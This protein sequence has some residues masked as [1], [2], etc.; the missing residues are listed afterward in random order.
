MSAGETARSF[1][2]EGLR[3]IVQRYEEESDEMVSRLFTGSRSRSAPPRPM[4]SKIE[5]VM[6]GSAALVKHG[7]VL[8]HLQIKRFTDLNR[9]RA[10]PGSN[11]RPQEWPKELLD[12]TEDVGGP[13]GLESFASLLRKKACEGI[14]ESQKKGRILSGLQIKSVQSGY[15]AGVDA[16][17]AQSCR[18]SPD[19]N[20]SVFVA[21]SGRRTVRRI[22]SSHSPHRSPRPRLGAVIVQADEGGGEEGEPRRGFEVHFAKCRALFRAHARE[23]IFAT[24]KKWEKECAFLQCFD[25]VPLEDE[26]DRA[27]Q[28]VKLRWSFRGPFAETS[29]TILERLPWFDIQNIATL[30]GRVQIIR[31]DYCLDATHSWK[32]GDSWAN[33]WFHVNR[34]YFDSADPIYYEQDRRFENHAQD[35]QSRH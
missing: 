16:P 14:K 19:G 24:T 35:T 17:S 32:S 29:S 7:V 25:A 20:G 4:K 2:A 11:T 6:G 10:A 33:E 9:A 21:D 1:A 22:V 28:C 3:S 26:V 15:V 27:L 12:L 31:G 30:R 5:S 23:G 13:E 18:S 8:S 34:F